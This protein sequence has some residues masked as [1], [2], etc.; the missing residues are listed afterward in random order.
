MQWCQQKK[1][2]EMKGM[3][4]LVPGKHLQVLEVSN[5]S[6]LA[7]SFSDPHKI[8]SMGGY[9]QVCMFSPILRKFLG[10]I[11]RKLREIRGWFLLVTVDMY[12]IKCIQ[13]IYNVNLYYTSCFR[14]V[15]CTL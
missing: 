4:I 14:Q 12:G 13:C 7:I 6:S 9:R 10:L 15:T 5:A 3:A 1:Q 2:K 11:F 8:I